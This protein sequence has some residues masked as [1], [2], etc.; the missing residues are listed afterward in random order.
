MTRS[1]SYYLK[2]PDAVLDYTFDTADG[3]TDDRQ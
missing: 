3:R 2:D 1:R